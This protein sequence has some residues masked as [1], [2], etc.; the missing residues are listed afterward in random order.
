MVFLIGPVRMAKTILTGL[1]EESRNEYSIIEGGI[2]LNS[3][4]NIF[5]HVVADVFCSDRFR[6]N[7]TYVVTAVNT[8]PFAIISGADQCAPNPCLNEGTCVVVGETYE[9]QCLNRFRGRNCE[10]GK[11]NYLILLPT[12]LLNKLKETL[13]CFHSLICI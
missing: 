10:T 8:L 4:T 7:W 12:S 6:A 13:M 3:S 1:Q 5:P 2:S 9:C 11:T